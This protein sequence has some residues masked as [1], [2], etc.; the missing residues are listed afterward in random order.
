MIKWKSG[1]L[2]PIKIICVFGNSE[3]GNYKKGGTIMVKG[4][5]PFKLVIK[6]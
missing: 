3:K 1:K 2:G 6:Y 4:T 5:F